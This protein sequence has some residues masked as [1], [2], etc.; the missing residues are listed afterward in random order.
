MSTSA[1]T[2]TQKARRC[3][4]RPLHCPP[5]PLGS[6][7]TRHYRLHAAEGFHEHRLSSSGQQAVTS[8]AGALE[9]FELE[10]LRRVAREVGVANVP[11]LGDQ[12]C[13][14]LLGG[15]GVLY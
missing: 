4:P 10:P 14:A 6:C 11:M 1:W 2:R 5:P 9:R 7:E 13:C 15:R 12:V 3:C 8:L